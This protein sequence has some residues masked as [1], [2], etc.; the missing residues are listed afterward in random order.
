M[1][2]D[3]YAPYPPNFRYPPYPRPRV[4]AAVLT[5]VSLWRL[6][7]VACALYGFSDAT[8]WSANFE[9]LSQQASLV[10]AIVYT[11]LLLYPVFT[12]GTRHEPASPWLRGAT[13]VLLLLVAGTFFGIM[14]GDFDYLPF[15]HVYTPLLVLADWLFVG[16]AQGA[17][18][19][20]HPLTWIAFPLAYLVYF[21]SAEVHRYLYPFLDPD[22]DEFAGMI[23]GLLAGVVAVGYLLYGTGKLKAAVGGQQ[24]GP[25]RPTAYTAP[26]WTR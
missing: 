14:G 15:E 12:G 18:R 20:W 17:C 11:G 13:T 1:T 2:A 24:E 8:G 7:I 19:W 16:R 22:R 3:G 21:L 10:T 5:G 9:G 6:A 4:S 23:G 26:G 25:P